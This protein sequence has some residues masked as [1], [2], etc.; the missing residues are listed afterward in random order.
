MVMGRLLFKRIISLT[1]PFMKF[2]PIMFIFKEY[3]RRGG[4]LLVLLFKASVKFDFWLTLHTEHAKT[5]PHLF[6]ILTDPF[7]ICYW[8]LN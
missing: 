8:A 4:L 2:L 3:Q 1:R 7:A 5:Q 6:L